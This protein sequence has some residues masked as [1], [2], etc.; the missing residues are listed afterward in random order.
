MQMAGIC[1]QMNI[2]KWMVVQEK[3]SSTVL[4]KPWQEWIRKK[5][6]NLFGDNSELY[7]DIS[8]ESYD[9]EE[10][11]N[12]FFKKIT[13][14]EQSEKTLVK[15]EDFLYEFDLQSFKQKYGENLSKEDLSVILYSLAEKFGVKF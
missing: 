2:W 8:S 11:I 5:K 9:I 14:Q 1:L 7:T 3:D 15:I 12:N 10:F 13:A 6:Q 4:E